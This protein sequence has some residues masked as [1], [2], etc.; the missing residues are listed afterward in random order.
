M[1]LISLRVSRRLE[2]FIT[3]PDLFLMVMD[4]NPFVPRMETSLT[5]VS[6]FPC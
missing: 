1:H 5:L 6:P 2:R 3:R 4:L